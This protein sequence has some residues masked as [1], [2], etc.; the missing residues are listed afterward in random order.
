MKKI[1][2]PFLLIWAAV[3]LQ[4]QEFG[5]ISIEDLQKAI[6]AKKVAIIDVN[7]QRSFQN[8]HIPGAINFSSQKQALKQLLPSN[9]NTLIVAYCGGPS[10]RAYLR[11]AK[12]AAELGYNNVRHL[13]AGISGWKKSGNKVAK[14]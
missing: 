6:L 14:K 12:A 13:S 9:K 3:S 10:C 1:L 8:G 7:G 4:G 5:D 11:G 2:I